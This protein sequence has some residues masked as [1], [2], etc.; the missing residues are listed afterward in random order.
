MTPL[1]LMLALGVQPER[2]EFREPVHDTFHEAILRQ[3]DEPSGVGVLLIG[4][5]MAHDEHWTVPGSYEHE[6]VVTPLTIDGRDTRDADVLATALAAAGFDVMQYSS[7]RADDE[8]HAQNPAMASRMGYEQSVDVA[9]AAR[10]T[11]RERAGTER[12]IL[13]GHSLGATRACHIADENVIGMGFLAGAYLSRTSAR[14]R[15]LAP[16]ALERH[17]AHDAD[18]DGRLSITE[19]SADAD[20]D[21]DGFV[22]GWELAAHERL[23]AIEETGVD[24]LDDP[25]RAHFRGDL[26]WAW[27]V[28][29]DGDWSILAICG[30][31]D[32]ISMHGPM[33]ETLEGVEVVYVAD[34]GHQLSV[35]RDGLVGAIDE[36]V[37]ARVVA[38]ATATADTDARA[39]D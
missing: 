21:G 36:D 18:G 7:I 12:V 35:E 33:L 39:V 11:L 6:G 9:R 37:V 2:L 15:D 10:A 16:E 34:R 17:A 14:S 3:A 4:G 38:W 24:P 30:G 25:A 23:A 8:L 5:G 1:I 27:D 26:P 13:I 19:I 22:S 29:K 20:R 28:I 31:L 32:T